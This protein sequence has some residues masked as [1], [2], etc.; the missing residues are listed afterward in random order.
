MPI[1]QIGKRRESLTGNSEIYKKHIVQ[2][3]EKRGYY[4]KASSDVEATFADCILSK[5]DEV[6]EY[7]L[8]AKATKISL[9]DS[10]FLLQLG[11]YLAGYVIRTPSNRFKMIL[12]CYNMRNL[13][14]FEQVFEKFESE[15]IEKIISNIVEVSQSNVRAIISKANSED[16]QRFFE[17]TTVIVANPAELQI[18]EE[19]IAPSVPTTPTLSDAEYAAEILNEFGDIEPL[20]G[21]DVSCLNLFELSTP[22]E[23]YIGKTPYRTPKSIYHEKPNISFPS[24]HLE[25]DKLYSFSEM[26]QDT[27]LGKFVDLNSVAAVDVEEF[28]KDESNRRIVIRILNRWIRNECRRVGLWFDR[29]T[30]SYF[31]PKKVNDDSP[32]TV[33][34]TPKSRRSKRELTK[35]MMTNGKISYWVHRAAGIFARKFWG[36]YYVQI[37]PRWLFSSDGIYPFEGPRADRLDRAFRKSIYN[38]NLNQLYDVLFWYRYIF[39]E[40]DVLG[41]LR[42]DNLTDA[43]G[44][45]LIKVAEQVK[46]ESDR[47]PNVEVEEEVEKLDTIESQRVSL[48]VKKL[49]DFM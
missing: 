31:F 48:F 44:K 12:A 1:W 11:K 23:L 7:W 24:F 43:R 36:D 40:T 30:R 47:K 15:A 29:R 42:L 21:S 3:L 16:I 32:I 37:R 10:S 41:N 8:E 14:L 46:V 45:R 28:D 35:P 26:N 5:K 2:Y 19:K 4:L 38:R 39:S 22:E 18:A 27:L 49:D 6:R 13:R 25:S 20:K 17:E 33:V 34:W 9:G